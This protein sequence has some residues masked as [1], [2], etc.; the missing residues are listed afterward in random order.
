[1]SATGALIVVAVL[2]LAYSNGANDNFK[3]VATLF[4]SGTCSYRQ[5]L[6]WATL[7]TLAG[8]LL[9]LTLAGGLVE[10]FKGKGLVPDAV[11]GQPAFLLA[12]SLGAALTV[13]LATWTGLPV[14]T[15]HALTG[16]LVGAGLLAAAGEV[17]L[18][19]LG[20]SFVVPLL[21]SPVA[22]LLLTV[23]VYPLFRWARRRSGVTSQTCV[24]VGAAYEEVRPGPDGA[25]LLVRTGA[26]L[27]VG[28]APACV[29]R[30][31]GRVA[32]LEAGR[33]LD[34]AHYLSG[35]AVGFARGLNDT[36]KIVALMLGAEA[37]PAGWGLA[38]VALVMAV[39]GVL[40]ARRVAETMSRK[41]TRMSPGQGF[42][43]N[44]A[45]SLLVAGAS[46]LG[47]PVSTTHV[48]VGALFGIGVVNGSARTRTVLTILLAWATTLPLGAAL[49]AGSYLLLRPFVGPVG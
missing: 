35:G 11:A 16:G 48:S 27:E 32:G 36:P 21:F 42:T 33:A 12:V 41:I 8:S 1:V 13:L 10:S 7:T 37:L 46:R 40:N 26:V 6:A 15:T 29:D 49:A 25:L 23:A 5:A 2:F 47:L 19:A 14:S 43:A 22:A 30:Y 9:A 24:C 39:G 4:G 28:Q 44:L 17:R 3:G 34:V 31:R 45:T 18:A 38:L 20:Q